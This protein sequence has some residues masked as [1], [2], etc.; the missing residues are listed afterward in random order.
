MN[1]IAQIFYDSECF[2]TSFLGILCR[3]TSM[4]QYVGY[5]WVVHESVRTF[6]LCNH[7][8]ARWSIDWFLCMWSGLRG[9]STHMPHHC[10]VKLED[11]SST[12]TGTHFFVSECW[13]FLW[14]THLH[15]LHF[16]G[17]LQVWRVS[18][19]GNSYHHPV[20]WWVHFQRMLTCMVSIRPVRAC[21]ILW[22]QPSICSSGLD[23]RVGSACTLESVSDDDVA[24]RDLRRLWFA[25]MIALCDGSTIRP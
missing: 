23:S 9:S 5:L 25:I 4:Q 17:N 15:P 22:Q 8:H 13:L 16:Y 10:Q 12:G 1:Q 3:Q 2:R 20:L 6:P 24:S 14:K 11:A 18:W 19:L 7:G 21:V